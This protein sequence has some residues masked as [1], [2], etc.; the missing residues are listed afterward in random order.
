MGLVHKSLREKELINVSFFD[1]IKLRLPWL[2]VGLGGAMVASII[3]SKFELTL[4]QTI[5]I[6][7]FIPIM[8]NMS[9]AIGT[10]TEIILIRALSN[11]KFNLGRYILRE[12]TEGFLMGL[13][14]ALLAYIFAFFLSQSS[15][16]ALMVAVA[17]VLCVTSATLL[18]CIT[19]LFLKLLGK[20]PAV[21]S[22]PF[23]TSLQDTVSLLIYLI[24]AT[25]ML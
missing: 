13:I 11:L 8:T 2:V 21:G 6:A 19:P 17:L 4:K 10:Q 16:V 5:T 7:F 22:G 24:I 18:A 14:L 12:V 15:Q 1:L 23:T 3:A 9:D 20:D 25:L